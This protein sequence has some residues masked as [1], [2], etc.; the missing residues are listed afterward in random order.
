MWYG[1]RSLTHTSVS[2]N[3]RTAYDYKWWQK[4]H[5]DWVKC[6]QKYFW[7]VSVAPLPAASHTYSIRDL[8]INQEMAK[9]VPSF[10]KSLATG[11]QV[12][13]LVCGLKSKISQKHGRM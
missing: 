5:F 6:N 1:T 7:S 3:S 12:S 13:Y 8:S 11:A 4:N 9:R 2:F 10:E